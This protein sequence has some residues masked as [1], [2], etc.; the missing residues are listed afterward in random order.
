MKF[1]HQ[2]SNLTAFNYAWAYQFNV[3]VETYAENLAVMRMT[4]SLRETLKASSVVCC[5]P[6]GLLILG[7]GLLLVFVIT[8]V[9][10]LRPD[11]N[12]VEPLAEI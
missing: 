6:I 9:I 12:H 2:I 10:H 8:N 4:F 5:R 11:R 7:L 1:L 3:N